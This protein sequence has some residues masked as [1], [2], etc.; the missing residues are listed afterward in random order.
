[1]FQK[2]LLREKQWEKAKDI[3]KI[4]KD[5][6]RNKSAKKIRQGIGELVE[7]DLFKTKDTDI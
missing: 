1:M 5:G 6:Q 7:Y 4:V 3:S 2:E